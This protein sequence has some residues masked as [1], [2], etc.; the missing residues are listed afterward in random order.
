MRTSESHDVEITQEDLDNLDYVATLFEEE[1]T[2]DL[3][4]FALSNVDY[5]QNHFVHVL[6]SV[7]PY[8]GLVRSDSTRKPAWELYRTIAERN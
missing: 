5:I 1:R 8:W 3:L 4:A 6:Q 7:E 2:E